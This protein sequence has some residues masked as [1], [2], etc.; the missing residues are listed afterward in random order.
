MTT[1]L[2]G[3]SLFT[4]IYSGLTS[5]YSLLAQQF[6]NGV[7][8][9]D[10]STARTSSL[11]NSTGLNQSFAQYLQTNFSS[12]DKDGDGV[13]TAEEL[14][15]LTNQISTQ[16]LTREQLS[17]LALAGTSGMSTSL[18]DTVMSHF[19]EIDTNRD[20]KVTNSEIKAYGVNSDKEKKQAEFANRAA[21]T[22]MSVFYGDDSSSAADSSSLLD[23]KYLQDENS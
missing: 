21:T 3:T 14:N 7:T 12:M 8:L 6:P 18:L 5:T 15:N 22:D 17:Q 4:G 2:D 13:I 23:Y 11:T 16:G 20:G 10:I 19:D 1:R 9:S